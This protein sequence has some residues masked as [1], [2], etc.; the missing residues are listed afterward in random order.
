MLILYT[1]NVKDYFEN[2]IEA[3]VAVFQNGSGITIEKNIDSF[4]LTSKYMFPLGVIVNEFI[5]NSMKYAF[6]GK[7][8][9]HIFLNIESDKDTVKVNLKDDGNGIPDEVMQKETES[10]GMLLIHSMCA[11]IGSKYSMFNNDGLELNIE[12][13]V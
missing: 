1:I 9:G 8:K 2:F 3:I 10:F 13:K 11:Q 6:K 12:F 4:N 7:E 5:T